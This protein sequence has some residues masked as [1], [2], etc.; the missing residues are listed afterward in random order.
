MTK[1]TA[2]FR[3]FA[4]APKNGFLRC[5]RLHLF[6]DGIDHKVRAKDFPLELPKPPIQRLPGTLSSTTAWA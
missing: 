6:G 5:Q 3:N 4:K 2:A 1:L